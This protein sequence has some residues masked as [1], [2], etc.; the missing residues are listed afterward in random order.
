MIVLES[1]ALPSGWMGSIKFYCPIVPVLGIGN[2]NPLPPLDKPNRTLAV[3]NLLLSPKE[4][5]NRR[6]N[7]CLKIVTRSMIRDWGAEFSNTATLQGTIQ[8]PYP[9]EPPVSRTLWTEWLKSIPFPRRSGK[10]KLHFQRHYLRGL[11]K[12]R[13]LLGDWLQETIPSR[14]GV[15]RRHKGSTGLYWWWAI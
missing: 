9:V 12:E 7:V 13:T 2:R 4:T 11:D 8:P 10:R 15:G 14:Y 3:I 5:T 1:F 6:Q